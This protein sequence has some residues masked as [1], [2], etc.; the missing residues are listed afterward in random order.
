MMA[1]AMMDDDRWRV[2]VDDDVLSSSSKIR[3]GWKKNDELRT[4]ESRK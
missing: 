3:Q 2:R 4:G 1:E